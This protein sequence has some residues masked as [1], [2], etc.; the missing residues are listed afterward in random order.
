MFASF[1]FIPCIASHF[2]LSF[3]PDG[4]LGPWLLSQRAPQTPGSP[5]LLNMGNSKAKFEVFGLD[6]PVLN[7]TVEWLG[8]V[9]LGAT[10]GMRIIGLVDLQLEYLP[11]LRG[12]RSLASGDVESSERTRW[13][14]LTVH[15]QT[16]IQF[17]LW[18]GS[19]SLSP[20]CHLQSRHPQFS[21][22]KEL[23]LPMEGP[24][25]GKGQ[26]VEGLLTSTAASSPVGP[27][28]FAYHPYS[29]FAPEV[30]VLLPRTWQVQ[31]SQAGPGKGRF[32]MW[33]PA[34]CFIIS[35]VVL[36]SCRR[37][38]PCWIYLYSRSLYSRSHRVSGWSKIRQMCLICCVT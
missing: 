33:C 22:C 16:A 29:A 35:S 38:L 24:S 26:P 12:R 10:S 1:R 9:D 32:G 37:T 13:E 3:F 25:P 34:P 21:L 31:V 17:A 19:P 28:Y 36:S 14:N 8:W 5:W 27:P 23:T 11:L 20:A 18:P 30:S 15:A 7:F 2:S 6:L 4:S